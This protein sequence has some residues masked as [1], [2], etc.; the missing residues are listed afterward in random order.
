MNNKTLLALTCS[1]GHWEK[2]AD[3]NY[4][5]EVSVGAANCALCSLYNQPSMPL[6]ERCIGCPVFSETNKKHCDG[7][8][9]REAASNYKK[10]RKWR[11]FAVNNKFRLRYDTTT[12]TYN[13]LRDT[14][15]ASA[16]KEVEFLK[17]LL[18]KGE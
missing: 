7:T 16:K 5:H 2:N 13:R 11:G 1:I 9:Y 18:P 14:F 6:E 15:R 17:L 4:L 3:A 12:V 10:W 8:P